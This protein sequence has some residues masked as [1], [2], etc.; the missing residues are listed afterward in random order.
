MFVSKQSSLYIRHSVY[1]VDN[2]I[3]LW[4]F[5]KLYYCV[6]IQK[7][8]GVTWQWCHKLEYCNAHNEATLQVCLHII[9]ASSLHISL[10]SRVISKMK[11][12][13][14]AT[15]FI[16]KIRIRF[17]YVLTE[18]FLKSLGR[19]NFSDSPP[20][21]EKAATHPLVGSVVGLDNKS[22][23]TVLI[24]SRFFPMLSLDPSRAMLWIIY[25]FSQL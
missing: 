13:G 12:I 1:N 23:V 2:G 19:K 18:M 20:L 14:T 17:Y 11:S 24:K 5:Y 10:W 8:A 16:L 3:L 25:D 4:E 9:N 15:E 6:T 7:K 22:G 21:F